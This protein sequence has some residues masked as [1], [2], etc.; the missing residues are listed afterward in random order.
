MLDS[1]SDSEVV[2]YSVGSDKQTSCKK[3]LFK[4]DDE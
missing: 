2:D 1:E 4:E 3:Q